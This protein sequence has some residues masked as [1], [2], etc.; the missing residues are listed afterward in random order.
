MTVE[1]RVASMTNERV[2][3]WLAELHDHLAATAERPVATDA[4]R[5]LG[6]AEAVSADV[7]TGDPPS[8]VVAKR[9]EQVRELLSHVD[10]TGD[11]AADEH[12][13]AARDRAERILRA[14]EADG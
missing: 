12:V 13:A 1:R 9:V 11:P 8:S 10:E 3:E 5:W 14:V 6:E 2:S 4:S 7:A